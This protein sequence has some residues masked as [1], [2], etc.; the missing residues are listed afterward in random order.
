[1]FTQSIDLRT[2]FLGLV[3]VVQRF[4]DG[5]KPEGR[6]GGIGCTYVSEDHNGAPSFPLTAVCIVG[7][8]L[9]DLGVLRATLVETGDD[10]YGA[11]TPDSVV[12]ANAESMGVEFSDDAKEFLRLAQ[13][14]Q[15]AGHTWG[16]SVR[17]ALSKTKANAKEAALR[18]IES[19]F[20]GWEREV[21]EPVVPIE[22]APLA[23]WERELL[24]GSESPF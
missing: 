10:Q 11:C 8:Y 16:D 7:Q 18:E 19:N 9:S 23:D 13:S 22:E 5:H 17:T 14:E 6:T 15:D 20:Y 3:N 12:W 2:A 4:G 21:P 24:Y 1:M